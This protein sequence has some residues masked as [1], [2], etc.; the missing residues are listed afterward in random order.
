MPEEPDKPSRIREEMRELSAYHGFVGALF[1]EEDETR[2]V[3][4]VA[5]AVP[6]FFSGPLAAIGIRVDGDAQHWLWKGQMCGAPL[7]AATAASLETV[8]EAASD[9]HARMNSL[10][11]G[12]NVPPPLCE[13][14]VSFLR[15]YQI[16]TLQR[17]LG[18]VV[19]GSEGPEA[20][21]PPQSTIL[22]AL[23]NHLAI[24]VENGRVRSALTEGSQ[25]LERKVRE[26]T[27]A[28]EA[29][30]RELDTLLAIN[31]AVTRHLDRDRLF[32]SIADS[33]RPVVPFDHMGILLLRGEKQD[34]IVYVH[35]SLDLPSGKSL[36]RKGTVLDWVLEHGRPLVASSCD[37]L[38]HF[39]FSFDAVRRMGMSAVCVLPLRSEEK[40]V[41]SLNF[42]SSAESV[43][44]FGFRQ[45]AHGMK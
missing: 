11:A 21:V 17:V 30:G 41:G 7:A 8:L 18:A 39:P 27:A 14:G 43:G 42:A 44:Y 29:K 20:L 40:A 24:V 19:L 6:Q 4:L 9:P 32:R 34:R 28:L 13:V 31:R 25:V 12:D 37:D 36:P 5:S 22:E 15:L 2:A 3:E 26:R 45:V 33:I 10:I 35:D 16:R 1:Q 38:R 23:A